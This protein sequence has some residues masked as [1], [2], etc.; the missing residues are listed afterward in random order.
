MHFLHDAHRG[1]TRF[2]QLLLDKHDT[3]V[4]IFLETGAV[5]GELSGGYP[6]KIGLSDQTG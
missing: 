2:V 1:A 4:V 5:G 3:K 6:L